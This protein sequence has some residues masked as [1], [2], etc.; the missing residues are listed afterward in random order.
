MPESSALNDGE[1]L[2]A[3]DIGSNSFHM[4]VARFVL[5]QLRIVDRLR[6]TVRMAAGLDGQGGLDAA[7]MARAL[8]CL[9]RFGER[10]RTMPPHRVR[11]IA[12]NTVRA[13]RNPQAFL[14]PAETALGHG[15]EI[16]SGREEARLIYLGVAQGLPPKAKRRLVIDIGGGSTEFIIGQGFEPLERESLQMGCVATTRRFF[17]DGKLSRK[18]WKEGLTEISAEFQ[19]FATTYRERGWQEV[20]GSSGTIKAIGQ[21]LSGMKLVRGAITDSGLAK[22]RDAMLAFERID[23]IDLPGLSEERRPVMP[24]GLLIMEACFNELRLKRMQV[25]QT[26]MREGVLYDML[27]RAQHRDPREASV[28]ALAQR[29]GVDIEHAARVEATALALFDQIAPAWDLGPDDRLMLSWAARIHEIGLA[30]AH[31]Q[32]HVHGAYVVEHSDIAGFSR[33][34]QQVLA[35]MIRSQR[36][37]IAKGSIE[38]LPERVTQNAIRNL[39]LLRIAVLLHRSHDRAALPVITLEGDA[40]RARLSLAHSW[41]DGHPLT[42]ADLDTE[43]EYLDAVGIRLEL[44]AL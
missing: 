3:V 11:V 43:V 7:V 10:V 16:V 2:A 5:G 4:V 26:A 9:S 35:A 23:E 30:I 12:T 40:R 21:I 41:L 1:L 28:S 6:E 36:R 25:C 34:E 37:S 24:G 15:I 39:A 27:G 42:R 44:V 18:R 29:Y 33:Q 31:S 17:P 20:I 32:H 22:A 8:E 14:V 38:A 19:Q 13:L